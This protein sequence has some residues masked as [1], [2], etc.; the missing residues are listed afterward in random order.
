MQWISVGDW[1]A[2]KIFTTIFVITTLVICAVR[3]R[4]F[5]RRMDA[6]PLAAFAPLKPL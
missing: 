1:G 5:V 4:M 2:V 6:M 3:R